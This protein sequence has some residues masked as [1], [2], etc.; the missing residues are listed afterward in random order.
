MSARPLPEPDASVV[1][2]TRMRRRH[3]R[4][5]ERIEQQVYPRPWSASLF[6]SELAMRSSR[7]YFVAR[8][9]RTVVG[10]AGMMLSGD[11]AH[12]TTIA[13]DPGWQRHGI[14]TR[15][16]L[17]LAHEAISRGTRNLTLEVR[18]ANTSAQ[19]MYRHFGLAPVGTRRNYYAETNEDALVMWVHD[20]DTD[21]FLD[22]LRRIEE[23]SNP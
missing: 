8:V 19:A 15:L 23:R 16:M 17:A 2:I 12:V 18:A 7:G 4:G 21:E 14:G 13:V 22:R 6:L 11:D 10:Y 3:V 9:G 5:V 20:I 1:E